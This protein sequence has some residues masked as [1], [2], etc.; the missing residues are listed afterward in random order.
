MSPAPLEDRRAR[1]LA[2]HLENNVLIEISPLIILTIA[3]VCFLAGLF[4][5]FVFRLPFIA[6]DKLRASLRKSPQT[7]S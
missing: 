1:R 5:G 3:I 6:C 7:A 2:V 4:A